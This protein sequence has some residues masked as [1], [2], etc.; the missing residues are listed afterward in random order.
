MFKRLIFIAIFFVATS[1]GIASTATAS[2]VNVVIDI[3][4]QRVYVSVDGKLV[5]NWLTSTARSGYRTPIGTYH[6]TR[7]YEEYYSVK[8]NGSPM[9]FS[10]FFYGGYAIHGTYEIKSLGTPA[11]HG[12][13]RLHPDN[14]KTLFYLVK[15]NGA[16]NTTIR[17]RA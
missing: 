17:V 9:P 6:P 4:D 8:Y 16:K 15:R 13:V 14:A 2:D 3:S 1:L 12:C 10:I 11:S 7:M 5:H